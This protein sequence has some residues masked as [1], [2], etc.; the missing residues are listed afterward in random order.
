M[1]NLLQYE[2]PKSP[3]VLYGTGWFVFGITLTASGWFSV[4]TSSEGLRELVP[5]DAA[6]FAAI[7][8]QTGVLSSAYFLARL[9][10]RRIYWFAFYLLTAALMVSFSYVGIR[11]VLG[12]RGAPPPISQSSDQTEPMVA[13]LLTLRHPSPAEVVSLAIAG[14]FAL[15]PLLGFM[16]TRPEQSNLSERVASVRRRMKVMSAQI[17]STEGLLVWSGRI[18][19][20]ALFNRPKIDPRAANFHAHL[21]TLR[22]TIQDALIPLDIP[23][24]LHEELSIR[25]LDMCSGAESLA[26]TT[27]G[28]FDREGLAALSDCL[29]TVQ[30]SEIEDSV[31][32][33]ARKLLLHHFTQFHKATR[34]FTWA[35][36]RRGTPLGKERFNDVGHEIFSPAEGQSTTVSNAGPYR[37]EENPSGPE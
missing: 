27:Q 10:R 17:E 36:G 12:A 21:L 33:E 9:T 24:M 16:G 28:K 30:S 20:G 11:K 18:V 6:L 7:G 5:P 29:D 14:A 31:K 4:T 25:L 23:S 2:R 26:S 34:R 19:S 32:E 1:L 15:I 35:D 3:D 13:R 8:L 22:E 37:F